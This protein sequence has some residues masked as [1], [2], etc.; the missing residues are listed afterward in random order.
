MGAGPP[1]TAPPVIG[2]QSCPAPPQAAHIPGIPMA[3]FRPPQASPVEQVGLLPVPQHGWP[4][5]PQV[6]QEF[7]AAATMHD[8]APW[9][10][11]GGG[12]P[13]TPAPPPVRHWL[14]V[15]ETRQDIVVPQAVCPAPP[16]TAAITGQQGWPVPPQVAH[17]PGT[18][19]A[20]F[21]PAHATPVLQVPALPVPQQGCPGPP[22]L[23]HTSSPG[24]EMQLIPFRQG[25]APAQQIWPLAPHE[26]HLPAPPSTR[27]PHATP[28]SQL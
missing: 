6:P 8:S 21:R 4:A 27:P 17:I 7:P 10:A 11:V 12:P 23:P 2:Q 1:S 14:P 18:P 19:L 20:L 26:R 3:A 24:A 25:A 15:V 13:S 5:A 9:Q 16:S 22:Q 28:P